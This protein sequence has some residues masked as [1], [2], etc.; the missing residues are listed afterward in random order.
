MGSMMKPIWIAA[1][2]AALSGTTALAADRDGAVKD[3]AQVVAASQLCPKLHVNQ[4]SVVLL[5][6]AHGIDFDRD[7]KELM[8]EV[9]RQ[10]KPWKDKSADAACV[11]GVMLYGPTGTNVPGLVDLN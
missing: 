7:Q 1:V 5:A 11:A 3:I 8:A 2:L 6:R 4:V 10:A 9:A